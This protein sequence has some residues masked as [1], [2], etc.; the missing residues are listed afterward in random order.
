MAKPPKEAPAIPTMRVTIKRPGSGP[1]TIRLAS[2]PAMAP[3]TIQLM[4]PMYLSSALGLSLGS[5]TP[6]SV[7]VGDWIDVWPPLGFSK[8]SLESRAPCFVL[9]YDCA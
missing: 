1:G 3:T 5:R 6:D 2:V 4:S 7:G 8:E 9:G